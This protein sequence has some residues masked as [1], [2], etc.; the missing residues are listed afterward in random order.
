MPRPHDAAATA[1]AA[2]V[3]S[4]LPMQAPVS[5]QTLPPAAETSRPGARCS[6]MPAR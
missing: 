2:F 6:P 4:S 3:M 1:Q 5:I